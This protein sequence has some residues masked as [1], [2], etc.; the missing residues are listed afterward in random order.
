M[1]RYTLAEAIEALE[2]GDELYTDY[3]APFRGTADHW[4][5]PSKITRHQ[6]RADVSTYDG[7]MYLQTYVVQPGHDC[8]ELYE[9]HGAPQ[10]IRSLAQAYLNRLYTLFDLHDYP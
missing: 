2:T 10:D 7:E 3:Y 4:R 6:L 8:Q 5:A 9:D 1:K